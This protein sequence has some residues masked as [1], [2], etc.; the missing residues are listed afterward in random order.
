[1][2]KN[3]SNFRDTFLSRTKSNLLIY[4]FIF[5]FIDEDNKTLKIRI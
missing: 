3:H 1:M 4:P 2:R 5:I